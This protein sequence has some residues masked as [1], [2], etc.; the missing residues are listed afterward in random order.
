M[1]EALKHPS[2]DDFYHHLRSLPH[3][4]NGEIIDGELIVSPRPAI[5][6]ARAGSRICRDVDYRFDR[7]AGGG[8]AP[9]GWWIL[10]EPELHF[11]LPG[12]THVLSPDIAG[13][14]RERL[15]YLPDTPFMTLAPDWV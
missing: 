9:G 6:H 12:M 15:P 5:R 13:W 7:K 4:R 2:F 8:D 11:Q 14:K 1:T 3:S 10:P